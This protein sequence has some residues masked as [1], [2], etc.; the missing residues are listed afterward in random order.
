MN[1]MRDVIKG[2]GR[3]V[4]VYQQPVK[5][6][7][8]NCYYDKMTS[9]SSGRCVFNESTVEGTAGNPPTIYQMIQAANESQ[10]A[11]EAAGGGVIRYKY[12]SCGRC[13][14]CNGKGYLETQRKRWIDCLVTWDPNMGSSTNTMTFTPAGTEGSTIVQLKTDPKRLKLFKN[15]YRVM[16]DGVECKISRPPV[17]R[18]LGNQTTMIIT[19]FTTDKPKIDTDEIIKD[20]TGAG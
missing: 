2:L 9:R 13:P 4:L 1:R 15:A 10:A 18:G 5:S 14:I 17:I 16:V 8:P 19:L 7:C 20:Y 12:F 11:F 3:S 6:A